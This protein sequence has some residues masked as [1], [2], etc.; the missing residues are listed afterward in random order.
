M[1]Q[2]FALPSSLLRFLL[3]ETL[4]QALAVTP[5]SWGTRAVPPWMV[6]F[7]SVTFCRAL[8]PV[9]EAGAMITRTITLLVAW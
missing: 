5:P 3:Y 7:G 4:L 2:L 9:A 6:F 1:G 8:A